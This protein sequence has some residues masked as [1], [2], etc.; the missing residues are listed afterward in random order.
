MRIDTNRHKVYTYFDKGEGYLIVITKS[1]IFLFKD[2]GDGRL[3][4]VGEA[5]RA[6][7]TIKH[8][9][10]AE[11]DLDT[12]GVVMLFKIMNTVYRVV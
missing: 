5:S 6:H 11:D 8:G 2:H 12:L 10:G 1:V 3:L 4:I 7:F 9:R